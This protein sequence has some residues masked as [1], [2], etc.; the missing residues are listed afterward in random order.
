MKL[1]RIIEN[2]PPNSFF[3]YTKGLYDIFITNLPTTA[4]QNNIGKK[5]KNLNDNVPFTHPDESFS[6]DFLKNFY[7]IYIY[8]Y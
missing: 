7:I 2:V 8:I 3:N 5:I 4:I 6:F 1:P